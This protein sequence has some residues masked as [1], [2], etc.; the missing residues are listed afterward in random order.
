MLRI[1]RS[2]N[3]GVG[4]ALIGEIEIEDIAELQRLLRLEELGRRIA[5]DLEEVTL[6]HR[7]AL[8]FLASCEA[9]GIKL[10]NCPSY[11]RVW[12][13]RETEAR[14]VKQEVGWL[15]AGQLLRLAN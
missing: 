14:V 3:A 5:F 10:E 9:D 8:K 12:I 7:D 6:V 13:D 15:G 1:Q 4:F 11:I 2:S